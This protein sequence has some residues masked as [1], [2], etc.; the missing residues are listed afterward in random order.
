M[1]NGSR[2]GPGAGGTGTAGT[3]GNGAGGTGSGAGGTGAGRSGTGT[4]S[5]AGA[6]GAGIGAAASLGPAIKYSAPIR[7][8]HPSNAVFDIVV[9]QSSS[10]ESFPESAGVLT[11]RPVFTVYLQVGAPKTWVMQYCMPKEV[12][13]GPTVVGG[14]VYIGNATPLKAPFPRVTVLPPVTMIERTSYIVVH[15]FLDKSGHFKDLAVLRA[16]DSGI[17][18]MLLPQLAQWVFR[19]ATRDGVPVLVEILLAIPPMEV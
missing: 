4:G 12:D 17:A 11:G 9:V 3:G 8:E 18:D 19:P 13:D 6:A 2:G 7:I 5:G 14:T 15:G 16:P 10:Q 1:G